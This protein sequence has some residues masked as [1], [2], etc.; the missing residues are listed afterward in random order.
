MLTSAA[1]ET[2]RGVEAVIVDEIHALAATK[3]GSHLALTLERLDHWVRSGGRPSPQRIGLSATQRPLEE[4]ARFLGGTDAPA[5]TASGGRGRSRSSTPACASR[6]RSRSSIPVDDMAELGTVIDEPDVRARPRPA[7]RAA[8]SGRPCTPACSSW[9]EEHR[10]TL[11]FVNARRLAERLATRLNELHW[12]GENRAAEADGTPARA[13]G[14]GEGPP[15]LAV[16]RAAAPDRGRAQVRS[17]Q[18]PGRHLQPRA[19]H[20][21][22]RGRPRHPGRVARRGRHA[23]CSASAG[24]ATRSARRAAASSS[25]S[26]GPTCS[27]PRSS[28]SACRPGQ[29]EETH[30]PRNPLDVLC[31]QIVA[32]CALD[33]WTLDDLADVVRRA[34]PFAE[35]SDEVLASVLDLL[36]GPLPVR[37]VRRAAAAH[38]V[39]PR[40]GHRSAAAPARS[41]S[42][43]P[44]PAPSPTA[45]SSA[46][47]SPTAPGSASST[48]RWS[49]RA[50]PA[51]RSCSAPPPGASRTSPSRR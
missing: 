21:H 15:R 27:R 33:E 23:G 26:T 29:I 19:R 44:T 48:R 20:R 1:R 12:E 47:P 35:L 46:S 45:G 24:P 10:S 43:S 4:I 5:T 8:R 9:C 13:R 22:G 30:Y 2:L 36:V 28:S 3:R 32:M 11:I 51:R 25:P 41:A 31:Q 38:R 7:R 18:G 50:A 49:T 16:A 42:R 14:A 39:G 17:A 37:G 34:A 40:R 6:S